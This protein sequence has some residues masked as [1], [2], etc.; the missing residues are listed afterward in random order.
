MIDIPEPEYQTK[1][2]HSFIVRN[3]PFLKRICSKYG[4]NPDGL[5]VKVFYGNPLKDDEPLGKALWGDNPKP[6][7]PKINTTVMD[8]SKIH[9]ILWRHGLSPRVYAVFAGRYKGKYSYKGTKVA[10]QLTDY[11]GKPKPKSQGQIDSVIDRVVKIGGQYSFDCEKR[12]FNARDIIGGKI[13]DV[14]PFN[15]N[16]GYKE[17]VKKIYIEK[18]RYGKVYYQDVPELG[19]KGGPRKSL[20]RIKYLKLEGVSFNGKVV[21]DIGMA[22]GFFCRYASQ[23]GAKRVIGIDKAKPVEAA[24]HLGNYLGHFNVDYMEA[25]LKQWRPPPEIPRADIL[26]FLSENLHVG[27]PVWLREARFVVFEDNS[28]EGRKRDK[29]GR[30]WTDWFSNIKFIGRAKDHG[31]KSIYWFSNDIAIENG[32]D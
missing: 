32:F 8:A 10:C 16:K 6:G 12:I 29:L 31:Q 24:F 18:G 4:R 27:V 15:F 30:P 22:G 19:L 5:C 20:D 14:Q 3:K 17:K 25:N 26:L 1:A 23:R 7:Q 21:W 2:K 28:R 13:V 9:N 11:L